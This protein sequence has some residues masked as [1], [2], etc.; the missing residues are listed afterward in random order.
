MLLS[1]KSERGIGRSSMLTSV[2]RTAGGAGAG[3]PETVSVDNPFRV[4]KPQ[5]ARPVPEAA[6]WE[7]ED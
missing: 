1:L 7:F 3:L 4:P 5:V 2:M 6:N